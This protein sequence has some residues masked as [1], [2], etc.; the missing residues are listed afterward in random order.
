MAEAPIN[1]PF[2]YIETSESNY[3]EIQ[4]IL[5][6]INGYSWFSFEIRKVLKWS[7]TYKTFRFI[8]L[9]PNMTIAR[10]NNPLNNI[11]I[12]KGDDWLK[13]ERISQ[14]KLKLEKIYDKIIY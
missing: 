5:L 13:I 1:P 8:G 2:L 10:C 6:F 14:R 12:M 11:I 7:E 3:E 4:K 9:Y